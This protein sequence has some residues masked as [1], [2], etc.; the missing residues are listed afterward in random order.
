MLKELLEKFGFNKNGVEP[1]LTMSNDGGLYGMNPPETLFGFTYHAHMIPPCKPEHTLILGYGQGTVA[2]LMR[3]IWGSDLKITGIDLKKYK[4]NYTEY[5]LRMVDAWD[6]IV[7]CTASPIKKRF[8]YI[9][10][11]LSN[12]LEIP[13]F[14]YTAEFA[15]RLR[16][17][18]KK[19][20][21]INTPVDD[22]SKLKAF[23]DYGWKFER[24]NNIYGTCISYWSVR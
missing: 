14:V 9:V 22:F 13:D 4:Y 6:Y 7:D 17:M 24:H 20:V 5:E 16:E 12:G 15:V 21:C 19:M 2:D 1:E 8:D 23:Y 18:C 3:K 10:V 11:D